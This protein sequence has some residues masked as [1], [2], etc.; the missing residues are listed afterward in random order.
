MEPHKL[1]LSLISSIILLRILE[2]CRLCNGTQSFEAQL[3]NDVI[4]YRTIMGKGLV[5]QFYI[6]Q[7]EL[8]KRLKFPMHPSF[9]KTINKV[10]EQ[11]QKVVAVQD[12]GNCSIFFIIILQGIPSI[13]I[14]MNFKAF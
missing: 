9:V 8:R 2:T 7:I 5:I 10:Q 4:K 12:L 11:S 1:S 14:R 3:L 13:V 6:S